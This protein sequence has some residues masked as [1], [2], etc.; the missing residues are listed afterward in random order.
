M[1]KARI[2]DENLVVDLGFLEAIAALQTSFTI[3][4]SK[5]RGATEDADYINSGL[6]IRAPGT[7]FPGLIAKGTFRK[8]G[9]RVL[10][11]WKRG[12]EIVVVELQGQ[13]WDRILLGCSDA[14]SLAAQINKA[15]AK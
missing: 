9:Q 8:N 14:E 11:L 1:A 4:L 7:G 6:G 12:D 13:K 3:P 15:S 2:N 5:V 10:S